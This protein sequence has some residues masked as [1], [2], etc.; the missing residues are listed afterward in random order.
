MTNRRPLVSVCIPTRNGARYLR[1]TFKCVENQTYPS[2]EVLVSDDGS[3]DGSL[4]IA[5]EYASTSRWSVQV[6]EHVPRGMADN[7]NDCI[8]T[9]RGE[10]VKLLFQDDLMAPTCVERLMDLVTAHK[11]VEFAFCARDLII[12]AEVATDALTRTTVDKYK[13]PHKGWTTLRVVQ[14]GAELLADPKLLE[15]PI[16]KVGEPTCVM[17]SRA[18]FDRMHGGFDRELPH[19]VDIDM[20]V[21][22]M[23][24][25]RVAFVDEVLAWFRLHLN[26]K[27]RENEAAGELDLDFRRYLGRLVRGDGF[28]HICRPVREHLLDMCMSMKVMDVVPAEEHEVARTNVL[29]SGDVDPRGE[30]SITTSVSYAFARRS[31]KLH[32]R[33]SRW[34]RLVG[35][36]R[37]GVLQSAYGY[38]ST[39]EGRVEKCGQWIGRVLGRL[40]RM[41]LQFG[42]AVCWM[43]AKT[44][45]KVLQCGCGNGED[46]SLLRKFGW[47]AQGVEEDSLAAHVARAHNGLEVHTGVLLPGLFDEGTFDGVI[48][49]DIL[50]LSDNPLNLIEEAWRLLK[51]DGV[52]VLAISSDTAHG[53]LSTGCS[54]NPAQDSQIGNQQ[55]WIDR[56][57]DIAANVEM[58][59]NDEVTVAVAAKTGM[60]HRTGPMPELV[61]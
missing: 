31:H 24:T 12:E 8:R 60:G 38:G 23:S 41:R 45:G 18:L 32:I 26:Q 51:C 9:S 5:R 33:G 14:L 49:R 61:G 1:E 13:Y 30:S 40:K 47:H 36:I 35:G 19:F 50:Q 55:Q 53:Q 16:N 57:R 6:I 42:E 4:A 37:E 20:W 15:Q 21:R 48:L 56:L 25:C 46:L 17:F 44:N 2:I 22:M 43:P 3:S 58:L 11:G 34:S 27:T 39:C 59:A 7:W 10:Y 29:N 28:R 52:L 54:D